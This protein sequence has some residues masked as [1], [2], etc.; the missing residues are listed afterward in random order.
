MLND[1]LP[2]L[3]EEIIIKASNPIIKLKHKGFNR[4]VVQIELNSDD[5]PD[6][7]IPKKR[8][9]RYLM[10]GETPLSNSQYK[11]WANGYDNF[12]ETNLLNAQTNL[13]AKQSEISAQLLVISNIQEVLD[14]LLL[15]IQ[16]KR[17][18]YS[19]IPASELYFNQRQ[20]LNLEIKQLENLRDPLVS[21]LVIENNLLDSLNEEVEDLEYDL[22]NQLKWSR[23]PKHGFLAMENETIE[24]TSQE[25]NSI[26][27]IVSE[28]E[29][30][31]LNIRYS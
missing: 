31:R 15:E 1:R 24:F 13:A 2:T 25:L 28:V 14:P 11:S 20:A 7:T 23:L 22:E 12:E 8:G 16:S 21:S 4:A 6:E 19:L 29:E 27:S 18:R 30:I 5:I 10:M 17:N 9:V 26:V 3:Q